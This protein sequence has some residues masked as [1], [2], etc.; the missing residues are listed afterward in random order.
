MKKREVICA[1]I[2][3]AAMLD[4]I[5][6]VGSVDVG[7]MTM[8]EYIPRAIMALIVA[9]IAVVIGEST[10]EE[11]EKKEAAPDGN[12]EAAQDNIV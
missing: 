7:S 11:K 10:P 9:V 12:Q 5:G 4:A 1:L 8:G 3:G 2:A 6:L